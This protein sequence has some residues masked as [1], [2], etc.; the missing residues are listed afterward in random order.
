[1]LEIDPKE[2]REI[3][4]VCFKEARRHTPTERMDNYVKILLN[5]AAE[6]FI[7]NFF[8]R[9]PRG[10]YIADDGKKMNF[11]SV[12]STLS[13]RLGKYAEVGKD[14]SYDP[15][16]GL[17]RLN[18][19]FREGGSI[20]LEPYYSGYFSI[21]FL[22][23]YSSLISEEDIPRFCE[24]A[25]FIAVRIPDWKP[26]AERIKFAVQKELMKNKISVTAVD[27]V[28]REK[29]NALG[30]KFNILVKQQSSNVK[31]KFS[32]NKVVKFYVKN[33]QFLANPDIFIGFVKQFET[34]VTKGNDLRIKKNGNSNDNHFWI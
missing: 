22:E 2:L 16:R 1:M 25:E 30:L 6:M 28:L 13:E 11:E 19:R 12:F 20:R 34:F 8:R 33:A 15:I 9:L 10:R 29:L 7:S 5:I 32:D 23:G 24:V 21:D 17:Y 4:S 27:A 31:I 3:E 18:I 14:D 26:I